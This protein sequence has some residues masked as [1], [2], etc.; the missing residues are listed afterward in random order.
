MTCNQGILKVMFHFL[1]PY[2]P[3]IPTVRIQDYCNT[4]RMHFLSP[5]GYLFRLTYAKSNQTQDKS[6]SNFRNFHQIRA[7][8]IR[9]IAKLNMSAD[10]CSSAKFSV[11]HYSRL[12][13]YSENVK[14]VI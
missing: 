12:L 10:Q 6:S 9:G 7:K 13:I 4:A 5:L 8:Y 3:A 1:N 2:H 14:L 11:F